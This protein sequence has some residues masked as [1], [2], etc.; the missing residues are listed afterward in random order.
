MSV[1]LWLFRT[2]GCDRAIFCC[3]TL[4]SWIWMPH[5]VRKFCPA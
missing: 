3:Q 1:S 5:T 2:D 4:G